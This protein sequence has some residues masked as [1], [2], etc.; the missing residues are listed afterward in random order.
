MLYIRR[1]DKIKLTPPNTLIINTC[2]YN[3]YKPLKTA[4]FDVDTQHVFLV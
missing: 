4:N 1:K 2:L 3:Y